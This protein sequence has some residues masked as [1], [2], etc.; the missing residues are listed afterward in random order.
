MDSSVISLVQFVYTSRL[1]AKTMP[2]K[3]VVLSKAAFGVDGQAQ[4]LARVVF[5]SSLVAS[6]IVSTFWHLASLMGDGAAPC[7]LEGVLGVLAVFTEAGTATL[8]PSLLERMEAAVLTRIRLRLAD[9]SLAHAL[10]HEELLHVDLFGSLFVAGSFWWH[11]FGLCRH[12]SWT[13]SGGIPTLFLRVW[14]V[15]KIS[16]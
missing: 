7:N 3:A 6:H 5:T 14:A 16:S 11:R 2:L 9:Y 8:L 1:S 13:S 4:R 10:V 12:G 15:W